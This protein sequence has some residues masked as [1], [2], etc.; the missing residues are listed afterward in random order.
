MYEKNHAQG[1]KPM[2][3]SVCLV[4]GLHAFY[5]EINDPSMQN[6]KNKTTVSKMESLMLRAT[7]PPRQN[8]DLT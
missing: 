1:G 4:G 3:G 5:N 2:K 8:P 6:V 7:P